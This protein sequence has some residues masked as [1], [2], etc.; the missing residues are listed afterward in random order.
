MEHKTSRRI[1]SLTQMCSNWNKNGPRH[2][3]MKCKRTIQT[4]P[5]I[6]H[7]HPS[8]HILH[9]RICQT[10]MSNKRTV[11]PR[12]LILYQIDRGV[13]HT[14][15]GNQ[16][17]QADQSDLQQIMSRSQCDYSTAPAGRSAP[18]SILIIGSSWLLSSASGKIDPNKLGAAF[19]L[20][21]T[22]AFVTHHWPPIMLIP[23]QP[24]IET[25]LKSGPSVF[26]VCSSSRCIVRQLF[27]SPTQQLAT[28]P[29][30]YPR[31]N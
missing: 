4:L 10:Q 11:Y 26:P 23:R 24:A 15:Q 20:P 18:L 28:A 12:P 14:Q 17:D 22:P 16:A 30:H 21:P 25:R 6:Y 19:C 2:A 1:Q 7:F 3:G 29:R 9:E 31:L 5:L 13:V 8:H 27:D